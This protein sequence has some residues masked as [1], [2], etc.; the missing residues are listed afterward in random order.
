MYGLLLL[1]LIIGNGANGT[2]SVLPL[3]FI[4]FLVALFI[5]KVSYRLLN[6]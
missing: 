1:Q 2:P 3:M 6:K 5:V 4:F